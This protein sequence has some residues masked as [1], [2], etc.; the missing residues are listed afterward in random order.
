[1]FFTT[2]RDETIIKSPTPFPMWFLLAQ[3]IG[4][5]T[6]FLARAHFCRSNSEHAGFFQSKKQQLENSQGSNAENHLS[7]AESSEVLLPNPNPSH[8]NFH[9]KPN[10]ITAFDSDFPLLRLL[11]LVV[12]ARQGRKKRGR[13][14]FQQRS[15]SPSQAL[16]RPA[17][18]PPRYLLAG[19]AQ[20]SSLPRQFS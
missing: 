5:T 4:P 16:R 17:P 13:F 7:V 19:Q 8:F 3:I 1:M 2:M 11:L 14:G 15:N 9:A 6:V 12:E 20:R 18:P 10:P